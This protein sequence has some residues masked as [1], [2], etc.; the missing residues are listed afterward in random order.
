MKKFDIGMILAHG[1]NYE[2]GENMELPW[3]Y[4]KEDMDRFRALTWDC[5]VIMG[6]IT[7]KS[8]KRPLEGRINIV[9]SKHA[10]TEDAIQ[11][12]GFI[13]RPSIESAISSVKEMC[14]VNDDRIFCIGGA[15]LYL[16]FND[17][18]NTIHIT[19]IMSYFPNADAFYKP[20]L[21]GFNLTMSSEMKLKNGLNIAFMQYD[22]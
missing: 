12:D 4:I 5:P 14:D 20:D 19:K 11:W 13:H 16:Y 6:M 7:R 15:S 1:L 9:V 3:G 22:R 10:N 17:I 18:V 2:I 21:D 8:L